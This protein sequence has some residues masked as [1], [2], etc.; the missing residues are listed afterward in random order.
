MTKQ[1]KEQFKNE[2]C[3]L[4]WKE[5]GTS[6]FYRSQKLPDTLILPICSKMEGTTQG[7]IL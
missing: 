3:E 1:R 7:T 4:F 5:I 6:K 2:T